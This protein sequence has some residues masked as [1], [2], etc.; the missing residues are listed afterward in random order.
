MPGSPGY[1]EREEMHLY[2]A[3]GSNLN[4]GQMEMR[5]PTAH[6]IAPAILPGW[7]LHFRGPLDIEEKENSYVPGYLFTIDDACLAA[8][9][10]YEGYPRLYDR[11]IVTV[12]IL[13]KSCAALVYTMVQKGT[14]RGPSPHYWE[15][16]IEG[17][18]QRG[19]QG[20]CLSHLQTALQESK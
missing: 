18:Q 4:I 14:P 10:I 8:L 15:T 3:Y 11:I 20:Y 17:Y 2:F 9:D 1:K 12:K 7:S 5:C 19:L 13:K 6:G 16:V